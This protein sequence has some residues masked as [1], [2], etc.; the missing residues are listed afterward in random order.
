MPAAS[1]S[2]KTPPSADTSALPSLPTD[3]RL[4]A[5]PSAQPKAD[6]ASLDAL[7]GLRVMLA[8]SSGEA[9]HDL[10]VPQ[11]LKLA[12]ERIEGLRAGTAG[13]KNI[14]KAAMERGMLRSLVVQFTHSTAPVAFH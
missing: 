13:S 3:A 14:Y 7:Q 9:V 11:L 10:A 2:A 8:V 4:L 6:E 5:L 12:H 1:P